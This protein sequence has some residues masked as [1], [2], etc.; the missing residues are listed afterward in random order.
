[1]VVYNLLFFT[2]AFQKYWNQVSDYSGLKMYLK[3]LSLK[4]ELTKNFITSNQMNSKM[5]PH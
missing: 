2:L 3:E 5:D 4:N 1:M